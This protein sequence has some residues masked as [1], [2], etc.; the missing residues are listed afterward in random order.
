MGFAAVLRFSAL[1][2]EYVC[3]ICINF[4][5]KKETYNSNHLLY[6]LQEHNVGLEVN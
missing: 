6:H 1:L 4:L 3:V 5:L 2:D